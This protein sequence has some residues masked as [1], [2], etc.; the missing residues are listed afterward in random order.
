[1]PGNWIA[2]FPDEASVNTFEVRVMEKKLESGK[3]LQSVEESVRRF[4]GCESAMKGE[5]V[6][7]EDED[8]GVLVTSLSSQIEEQRL[9]RMEDAKKVE[10]K[11]AK[12]KEWVTN[13]L[14]ELE[15]QNA[16]LREQNAKCN[17]Q[18]ELL[19]GRLAHLSSLH[20]G[21]DRDENDS[22][23]GSL[24][25]DRPGSHES[26]PDRIHC[27]GIYVPSRPATLGRNPRS[28][29]RSPGSL[30]RASS[31][32]TDGRYNDLSSKT[33]HHHRRIPRLEV[34]KRTSRGS[35]VD[36]GS[37]DLETPQSLSPKSPLEAM[38]DSLTQT[39]VGGS[40]PR[41][42]P[43][44]LS[45]HNKPVPQPRTKN[46]P[47]NLFTKSADSLDIFNKSNESNHLNQSLERLSV[48]GGDGRLSRVKDEVHDYSEIYTPNNE[49]P[50]WG[51][52][53]PFDK[54]PTPPLHR[55][56]SWESR[57]YQ[58]A[59]KGLS[60]AD[61]GTD[62]RL[63]RHSTGLGS[64]PEIHVP[65]YAAVK[66]R[67]SQI[68]SVP[69]TGDSSDSSDG[70]DHCGG[71]GENLGGS[72]GRLSSSHTPSSNESSSSSPSKSKT[73][74]L[75]PAKLSSSSPSKSVRRDMS[76]ES[77]MSDDYA[78]P[79]DARS[80]T[81]SIESAQAPTISA[82]TSCI[83]TT[84]NTLTSSQFSQI[85]Q[86]LGVISPRYETSLEKSGYLTKLGGKLKTWK[87]RYFVLKDGSLSYWKSQSEIHR[88]PA[89]EISLDH[90]CSVARS[91]G[92]HTFEVN[93]GKKVYYLTADNTT[94]VE[95]WVRVL[96]NVLRRNATRLLLS[97]EDNKPTI[98][99]WLTKVKHGHPKHCWCVLI[100]R[101][102]I[103][104]KSPTD[105]TPL[106][107]INMRDS[108][109]EEVERMSDSEGEDQH[110]EEGQT[111]LT[112]GLF[113]SH[114]GPTYL[115]CPSKQEKD[116]WL[117]HLTVVS[118]GGS[119]V[120]TQ[121]EQL[122]QKMMELDG[123]PN[124]VLWRHPTLLYSKEPITSPFMTLPT[125]QL[126]SEAVKLFKS[127]QL[128][129]SV[130]MDSSAIDYHVVL[131]QNALHLCLTHPELQSEL[132]CGLIKQ[133]SAHT[134]AK[135]GVQVTKTLN[136]IKHSRNLLLCATQSLFL[137]DSSGAQKASPTLGAGQGIPIDPKINPPPFT[138]IQGWQ[139]LSL[140][141]SLFIPKNNKLLWY[142]KAHLQRYSDT[143][144]EIGKYAIY[145]ARALQRTIEKGGREA[146]PSRME[147]L[148][149][150]LKNPYH[151]SLPHAIPVHM[152][153]GTYQ[154]VGFDG[155]TTIEE[156]LVS[157]NQELCCRDVHMSGFAIFS[158]DPI[159]KELEHCLNHNAKVIYLHFFYLKLIYTLVKVLMS[160][161][162]LYWK[163]AAKHETE[164]EKLLLCYQV[165]EQIQ[166]GKF[167]VTKELALELATLMA[168][169]DM[170]EVNTERSR[171]SGS[172]GPS[173]S[174]VQQAYNKF[175]P[176]R[177]KEG[178]SEEEKKSLWDSLQEKWLSL[179]GRGQADCVRIFLTCARKWP[180][181]G[182]TLF[183]ATTSYPNYSE[184]VQQGSKTTPVWVAVSEEAV[185]LL[186]KCSMQPIVKYIYGN[187]VT[188]GGCQ[189]DFMLVVHTP[190]DESAFHP[191]GTHKLLLCMSKPK[192]LELTLL[193][194][195]YMNALGR[196]VPGT[197]QTGTLTR[198]GSSR[199]CRGGHAPPPIPGGGQPDL[200]Q[201]TNDVE[202]KDAKKRFNTES[203]ALV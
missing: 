167:P 98:Q 162:R 141:V 137:C 17:V 27:E 118:G 165:N 105:Q 1:M 23:R 18:L 51:E 106:G 136:K 156:F 63:H 64:Y 43:S 121:Y 28:K 131:C 26:L 104:F 24:D 192:I 114:Q 83:E 100:G 87:K 102:F 32:D 76:F 15:E 120:G 128:F 190:D 174:H 45:P 93:T 30:R 34:E 19:R 66:G 146:K 57:I 55:F 22:S 73:S 171:G 42:L 194:A 21:K 155:S 41:R 134:Q 6:S 116:S 183:P 193:I 158:D 60:V 185:T 189:E 46:V 74:S 90:G 163:Y 47:P 178:L 191:P 85:H 10:A 135:P 152:L 140:A 81:V 202:K 31:S 113:P 127:C 33:H 126:Q 52:G 108:R 129:T 97:K 153:N 133:T 154:V 71:S 107:Q 149:V 132:F 119:N 172:G 125:P 169:I 2:Y 58:V 72:G 144:T 161:N 94:L 159:E 36:S 95:E 4:D 182:S 49:L 166:E 35:K 61:L 179:R 147:V 65:V 199:S 181:F 122:I 40:L 186:E 53:A 117:Y 12:I 160:W 170:G 201:M 8:T 138:F 103:Y 68:R 139:F 59:Q 130:H 14:K 180:F 70:E 187:V 77:G 123:D 164:K 67:A 150:L 96:Q 13:K 143:K 86:S 82:R 84:T 115:I 111:E 44:S 7:L 99:G 195:D 16:V 48:S 39:A 124:C 198:H 200:L 80:D 11:A 89:G 151:H 173:L 142:L 78:I 92:A 79:P 88:K 20:N 110:E 157:L 75:S 148:S 188:F 69:F 145:C 203:P 177:Y 9:L 3:H 184:P 168:Q 25:G 50:P 176:Q 56:P 62:D 5:K 109:V 29:S 38:L 91:E 196:G 197:P 37:I 112:I 101:M 54:P 175:Y